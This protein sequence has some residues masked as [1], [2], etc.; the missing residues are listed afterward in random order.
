[1]KHVRGEVRIYGNVVFYRVYVGKTLVLCDNTHV[2][3]WP[4]IL[5]QA[6][7]EVYVLRRLTGVHKIKFTDY[8]TLVERAKI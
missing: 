2:S 7:N 6:S 1:M 3:R 5:K 8:E 4:E